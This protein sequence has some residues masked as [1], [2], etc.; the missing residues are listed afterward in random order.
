MM[1]IMKLVKST[2]IMMIKTKHLD[3]LSAP[4]TEEMSIRALGKQKFLTVA[5]ISAMFTINY[6]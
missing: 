4:W 3:Q 1:T 2:M 6:Y 5:H